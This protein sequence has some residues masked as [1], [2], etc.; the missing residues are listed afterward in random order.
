MITVV[1]AS[2]GELI[3]RQAG[4]MSSV[5]SASSVAV[6]GHWTISHCAWARLRSCRAAQRSRAIVGETDTDRYARWIVVGIVA[7]A[8]LFVLRFA[9]PF[10]VRFLLP[11]AIVVSS[12]TWSCAMCGR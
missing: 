6:S 2:S 8:G 4:L 7:M 12:S 11:A 9:G 3:L 5:I 10:V 1:D